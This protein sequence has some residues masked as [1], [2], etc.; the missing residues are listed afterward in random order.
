M[1]S[2]WKKLE[3]IGQ[4]PELK[5]ESTQQPVLV[6]K[7]SIRCSISAMVWDRLKRNWKDE[8]SGKITAYYLDLINHRK[9]SDAI[10]QEFNVHH[11][12]PQVI[13]IKD[14]KATY[15]NSHM[16]ISYQEILS[17]V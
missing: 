11:E 7:H 9:I 17:Q 12:S 2:S 13:I 15:D 4:I 6:F 5:K 3:H 10:A 14:G 8:D 1:N 16:G